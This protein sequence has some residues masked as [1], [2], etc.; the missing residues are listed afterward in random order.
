VI[1]DLGPIEQRDRSALQDFVGNGGGLLLVPG[2]ST[3]PARVNASLATGERFLPARLGPRRLHA[4]GTEVALNPAS[5][6]HPALVVFQDTSEID[7]G[8]AR[9]KQTFDLDI[10]KE[11]GSV[12]ACRFGDGRPAIVERKLGQGKVLLCAAGFGTSA[13]NLPYKPAFVPMVHQL[14][15]YLAAGPAAQHNVPVGGQIRARFEVKEAGKPARLTDPAGRTSV[16]PTA[17]GSDGVVLTYGSTERAGTYRVGL[18]STDNR[19][20][21]AVNREPSESDLSR[22]D[23]GR[24]M[25]ALGPAQVHFARYTDDIGSIVRQSRQGIEHWRTAL[26]AALGLLFLEALLAKSFGHRG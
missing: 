10:G 17:M 22:V 21:F 25:A 19:E 11:E 20:A 12:T 2:P 23:A 3:D 5:M 18:G 9:F 4:E 26:F 15:A 7:L 8:S 24:I 6:T 14:A 1:S 16:V 13:G